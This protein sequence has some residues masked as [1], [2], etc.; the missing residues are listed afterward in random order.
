[1]ALGEDTEPDDRDERLW[2]A[3]EMYRTL[4]ED[5]YLEKA[6]QLFNTLQTEG[7][8]MVSMGWGNVSGFAGW[9]LLEDLL[10][11]PDSDFGKS[12]SCAEKGNTHHSGKK[13][14]EEKT[15]GFSRN[16]WRHSRLRLS[17]S[18]H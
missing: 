13:N 9:S 2:A 4:Q 5:K 14:A 1:M 18:W 3:A 6:E 11:T 7:K 15:E 16:I 8:D 12:I 10:K 17:G